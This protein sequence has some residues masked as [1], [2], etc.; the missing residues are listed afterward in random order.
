MSLPVSRAVLTDAS[1]CDN[2]PAGGDGAILASA[3]PVIEADDLVKCEDCSHV[4][5]PEMRGTIEPH[6]EETL[7]PHCEAC[8]S[9]WISL[10]P[11]E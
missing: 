10:W 6:G 7:T 3:W 8:L 4:G 1:P 5:K 11:K 2:I 9:S